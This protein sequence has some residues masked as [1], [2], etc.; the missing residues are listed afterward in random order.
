MTANRI[1]FLPKSADNHF[2]GR[3]AALVVL[4]F[5]LLIRTIMSVGSIVNGYNTATTA[6]GIP[7]DKYPPDAAQTVL[8]LFGLTAMSNILICL[9]GFVILMRY[10]TLVPFMFGILLLQQL[11]RYVFM[12]FLPI[13][14]VG[15]PPGPMMHVIIITLVVSGLALSLWPRR[16]A[17]IA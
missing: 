3:K 7:L 2:R 17:A 14:R 6:D 1:Q 9:I 11:S 13:V 10:R 12:Q 16:E 4:G 8:S 15:A 5:V